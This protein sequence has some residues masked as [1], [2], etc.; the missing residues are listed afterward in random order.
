MNGLT[1][2]NPL[3]TLVNKP[4]FLI[5][6]PYIGTMG[7]WSLILIFQLLISVVFIQCA[8][9]TCLLIAIT[10]IALASLS[11]LS[12]E[13][14]TNAT[15]SYLD[16][17]GY[18]APPEREHANHWDTSQEITQKI[19]ALRQRYPEVAIFCMPESSCKFA[20]NNYPSMTASWLDA[21][22]HDD[23]SL[24][25]GSH[26]QHENKLFNCL[27]CVQKGPIIST[28]DKRSPMPFGEYVPFP[29]NTIKSVEQLFLN[30]KRKFYAGDSTAPSILTERN[31]FTC[32]PQI[33]Y[34]LYFSSGDPGIT[35]KVKLPH[36][37]PV[38][39]ISNDTW[40]A[41]TPY[42]Q[43]LLLLL[44][45]YRAV[46][47]NRPILYIAHTGGWWLSEDGAIVTLQT[48]TTF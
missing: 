9:R 36:D 23:C 3:I 40:F 31:G 15:P 32:I 18:I 48:I 47:W 41:K 25:I 5:P 13:S 6:L 11:I 42:F 19:F 12:D 44:C 4:L 8:S 10:V 46:E 33:C 21:V 28:Y 7:L 45:R 26:R 29:W 2:A 34:E 30:N 16:T 17:I 39:G 20:L 38:L 35:I 24:L 1:V 37:I 22:L 27:Y 43:Q 14:T